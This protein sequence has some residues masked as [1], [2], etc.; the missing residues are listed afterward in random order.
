MHFYHKFF[1]AT[2]QIWEI[3]RNKNLLNFFFF[4]KSLWAAENFCQLNQCNV[5]LPI[6]ILFRTTI[7][8]NPGLII[9]FNVSKKKNFSIPKLISSKKTKKSPLW[10]FQGVSLTYRS[11]LR[12]ELSR[13]TYKFLIY[14][15]LN[16]SKFSNFFIVQ[17]FL[18]IYILL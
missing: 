12:N 2:A 4:P 9:W 16:I 7:K 10:K 15:I 11:S 3:P 18:F 5:W 17:N 14:L 8:I 1:R 6:F 13:K